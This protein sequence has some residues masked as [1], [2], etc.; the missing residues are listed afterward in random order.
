LPLRRKE[1]EAA[2]TS[3][4]VAQASAIAQLSHE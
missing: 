2:D 3:R 4:A 1:A